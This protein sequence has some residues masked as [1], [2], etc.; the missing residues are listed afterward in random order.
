MWFASMQWDSVWETNTMVEHGPLEPRCE[1][2]MEGHVNVCVTG[3]LMSTVCV[4]RILMNTV[5]V[6]VLLRVRRTRPNTRLTAVWDSEGQNNISESG[7]YGSPASAGKMRRSRSDRSKTDDHI[8]ISPRKG[9]AERIP[10]GGTAGG[11]RAPRGCRAGDGR[12]SIGSRRA[13]TAT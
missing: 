4:T 1:G 11:S 3:T 8:H 7:P 5:C 2:H 10:A 12:R 9:R 6:V 13:L